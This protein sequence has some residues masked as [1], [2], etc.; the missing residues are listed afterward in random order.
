[1]SSTNAD[2][3]TRLLMGIAATGP[4]WVWIHAPK[5]QRLVKS[6]QSGSFGRSSRRAS[7]HR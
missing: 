5:G 7:T 2:N 1:M 3:D 6:F 4:Q